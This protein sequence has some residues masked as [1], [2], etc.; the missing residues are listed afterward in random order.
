[1]MNAVHLQIAS[2]VCLCTSLEYHCNAGLSRRICEVFDYST[3]ILRYVITV[4]VVFYCCNLQW[5]T[6]LSDLRLCVRTWRLQYPRDCVWQ[7]LLASSMLLS[8]SRAIRCTV[9]FL[10]GAS[11]SFAG[12]GGCSAKL[13]LNQSKASEGEL[14][15]R[16]TWRAQVTSQH[17]THE[18]VN[19]TVADEYVTSFIIECLLS[20]H[21][22]RSTISRV[23]WSEQPQPAYEYGIAYSIT[24]G[25]SLATNSTPSV[26]SLDCS[27]DRKDTIAIC[28]KNLM[29]H[30]F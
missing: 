21:M 7:T 17:V 13:L 19:L 25:T 1:M 2:S 23:E 26:S 6:I 29:Q 3:S 15:S 28:M 18:D 30:F 22:R 11:N 5:S 10:T 16:R 24:I 8:D 9:S 4:V 14:V 20:A 12:C 27:G